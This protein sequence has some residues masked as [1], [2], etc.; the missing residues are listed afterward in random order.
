MTILSSSLPSIENR[1]WSKVDRSG[2]LDACW[3]WMG[4]R[5]YSGY[6]Q[7][8][9]HPY[10]PVVAS[11]FA[12]EIK[13]GP[14]PVGFFVCHKCDNPPCCNPAHLFLGTQ[15]DNMDDMAIKGRRA[16]NSNASLTKE[17]VIEIRSKYR[18]RKYTQMKLAEEFGIDQSTVSLIINRKTWPDI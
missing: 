2:G 17:M 10:H 1:F 7:F 4:H 9:L 13:I 11:R 6:G 15:Q 18:P 8:K 12:Y 16:I 3:P 5:I 14:I